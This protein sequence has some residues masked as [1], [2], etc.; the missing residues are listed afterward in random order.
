VPP[1]QKGL[2]GG[3]VRK[4]LDHLGRRP[5]FNRNVQREQ[6]PALSVEQGARVGVGQVPD[7]VPDCVEVPRGGDRR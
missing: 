4:D 7:D 1:F 2:R 3:S 6:S 5:S